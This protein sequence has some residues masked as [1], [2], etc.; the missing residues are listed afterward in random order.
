MDD[1]ILPWIVLGGVLAVVL[2]LFCILIVCVQR[3]RA[4]VRRLQ[5]EAGRLKTETAEARAEAGQR[6]A[7]ERQR[8]QRLD[9]QR[10]VLEEPPSDW[11]PEDG[12]QDR[13]AGG[14]DEV[15]IAMTHPLRVTILGLTGPVPQACHCI[16]EIPGKPRSRLKTLSASGGV[17]PTWNHEAELYDFCA[18]DSLVFYLFGQ[19]ACLGEA[20]LMSEAFTPVGFD[21]EL[22]ITRA[23]A[24]SQAAW[25]CQRCSLVNTGSNAVCEACGAEPP[26][27]SQAPAPAVSLRV[28]VTMAVWAPSTMPYFVARWAAVNSR[29]QAVALGEG[30]MRNDWLG[31]VGFRFLAK[32]PLAISAL[33]RQAHAGILREPVAVTL[34]SA[35]TQVPLATANVGPRSVV[36]GGYAFSPL[37]QPVLLEEGKE[38]R[39]SQQCAI[40]MGDM[41]FDGIVDERELHDWSAAQHAEFL[42]GVYLDGFGFP[43]RADDDGRFLNRYRRAG[44]LNFKML[45]E[46]P[47]G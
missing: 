20:A 44:M 37:D 26:A 35:E 10:A 29:T 46:D 5:L 36:E 28:Q 31:D 42:G 40:G 33:G 14:I 43:S 15:V 9:P 7:E 3:Y 27:R 21:G 32:T 23:R 22:P 41:W 6:R 18:G 16:C 30:A 17:T 47:A 12:V 38:Y 1:S 25:A 24:S 13:T 11:S 19:D 34:W 2:V 45:G 8:S 4:E 39:L